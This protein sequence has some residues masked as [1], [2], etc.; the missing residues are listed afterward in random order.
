M[1]YRLNITHDLDMKHDHFVMDQSCTDP[2][3]R[4]GGG[5]TGGLN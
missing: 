1:Q 5:G 3:R 2:E 4:F